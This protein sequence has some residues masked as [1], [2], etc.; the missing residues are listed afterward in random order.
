MDLTGVEDGLVGADELVGVVDG[1]LSVVD[2]LV[3]VVDGVMS[4]GDKSVGGNGVAGE[5]VGD[6]SVGG[7]HSVLCLVTNCEINSHFLF[8]NLQL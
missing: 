6:E 1:V 2:E 8:L 4:V 3:G 7:E 5:A